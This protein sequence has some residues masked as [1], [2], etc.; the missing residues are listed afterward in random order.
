M[1]VHGYQIKSLNNKIHN[2]SMYCKI[3]NLWYKQEFRFLFISTLFE[4][5]NICNGQTITY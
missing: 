1:Y 2:Y 4:F 3:L 5:Q